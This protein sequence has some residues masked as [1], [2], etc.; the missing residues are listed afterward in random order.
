[1]SVAEIMPPRLSAEEI[2]DLTRAIEHLR[3]ASFAA[4][5]T[6]LLGANVEAIGRALPAGARKVVARASERALRAALGV[7][8][9]TIDARRR[10]T[11]SP[12]LHVA[13]AA[14]SGAIG[15]ALGVAGLP[16]EL[17]VSTTILMRSIAEIARA[18][19]EDLNRPEGALACV[20][21][22]ALGGP[23]GAGEAVLESGYFAVRSALA[24]SVSESA[25]FLAARGVAGESAPA[26]VR[27]LAQ[28]A[29]RFG[30]VVSEKLAGAGRA[31]PG[32]ARRRGD[33]RRL[34]GPF[35]DAGARPFHHPPSRARARRRGRAFRTA[36]PRA[37]K[38]KFGPFMQ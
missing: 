20:E 5:M 7:A 8:L 3:G 30:V 25:R 2:E 27:L 6:N 16:F 15:G 36:P 32:R 17:P 22:F 23:A 21:V 38:L 37:A 24:V 14:A 18:E 13:A 19:G 10:P 34:R 9:R 35:P 29:A 33:Q 28:I 26:L 11:V 31:A 1:M 12:R 4:R